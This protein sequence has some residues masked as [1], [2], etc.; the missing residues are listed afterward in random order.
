MR[1][2]HISHKTDLGFPLIRSVSILFILTYNVLLSS[3][4]VYLGP[5]HYS[6]C[7]I[8]QILM[9]CHKKRERDNKEPIN[10]IFQLSFR[11]CHQITLTSFTY[12]VKLCCWVTKWTR[13]IL[14]YLVFYSLKSS[15]LGLYWQTFY[16]ISYTW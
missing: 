16:Y 14:E 11:G 15:N 12:S 8:I 7:L 1:K 3:I 10:I 4:S 6:V 9:L 13:E 2:T 5:F